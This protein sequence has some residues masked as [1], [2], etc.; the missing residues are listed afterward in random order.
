MIDDNKVREAQ[1]ILKR[2]FRKRKKEFRKEGLT[3][4]DIDDIIDFDFEDDF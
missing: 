2:E 1:E 3:D 4:L